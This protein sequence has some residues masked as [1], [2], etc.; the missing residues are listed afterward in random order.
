MLAISPVKHGASRQADLAA[1]AKGPPALYVG[2]DLGQLRLRGGEQSS[3]SRPRSAAKA[4]LRQTI[5][6]S[7]RSP[8]L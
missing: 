6:R 3:R 1:P 5:R 7:P 2:L 8:A 4:L